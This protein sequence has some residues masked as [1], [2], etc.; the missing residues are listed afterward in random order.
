MLLDGQ[1]NNPKTKIEK[2][3]RGNEGG[4]RKGEKTKQNGKG[5]LAGMKIPKVFVTDIKNASKRSKS[6][7]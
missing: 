4:E 5:K 2:R 7:F 1:G 6:S 3:F